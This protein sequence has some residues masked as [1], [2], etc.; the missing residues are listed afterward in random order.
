MSKEDFVS[1]FELTLVSANLDIISLTLIDDNTIQITFKGG[2]TR[3]VNIEADSYGA[4]IL[5]IM[6]YAF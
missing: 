4:I 5:D 2:G 3:R 6:K 1:I